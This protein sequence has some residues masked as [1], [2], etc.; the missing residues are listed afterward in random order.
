LIGP[1]IG[2]RQA[3]A[4]TVCSLNA[5]S[6]IFAERTP[7]DMDQCIRTVDLDAG[8]KAILPF[9]MSI[10][11]G[12]NIVEGHRASLAGRDLDPVHVTVQCCYII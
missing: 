1:Y 9:L 7:D 4:V 8:T 5:V 2:D 6:G 12:N 10:S 3:G 11:T